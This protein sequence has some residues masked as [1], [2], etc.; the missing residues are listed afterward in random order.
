[1]NISPNQLAAFLDAEAEL[2]GHLP[3]PDEAARHFGRQRAAILAP[4]AAPTGFC[5]HP[6][7]H[8]G[9]G[10]H[11]PFGLAYRLPH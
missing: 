3:S 5:R 7:P 2:R 1:M 4:T 9:P 6:A 8:R 10:R 11:R